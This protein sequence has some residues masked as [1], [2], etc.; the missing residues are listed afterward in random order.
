MASSWALSW[1]G[2]W[3]NSWGLYGTTSKAK[4]RR[5]RYIVDVDGE[6]FEVATQRQAEELLLTLRELAEQSAK[7]DEW[8]DKAPP[9]I[10]VNVKSGKIGKAI[11]DAVKSTQQAIDN[12]YEVTVRTP[13]E[14]KLRDEIR[15]EVERSI[16]QEY[17][18]LIA[19]L[20]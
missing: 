10:K 17:E 14:R 7:R 15:K 1:A 11:D 9:Q 16:R 3:G 18:A 12:A 20:L 4:G 8:S 2:S 13:A 5:K 6:F 19:L